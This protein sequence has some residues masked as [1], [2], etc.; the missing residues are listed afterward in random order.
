[1]FLSNCWSVANK[2]DLFNNYV[3]SHNF[4]CYCLT[5]TKLDAKVD[6]KVFG[7]R[8]YSIF[9]LD[10]SRNAGGVAIFLSNLINCRRVTIN[11]DGVFSFDIVAVDI[12]QCTG[13]NFRVICLYRPPSCSFNDSLKLF[14]T[15]SQLLRNVDDFLVCGDFNFPEMSWNPPIPHSAVSTVLVDLILQF[16]MTQ[17]VLSATHRDG[18]IL[19]LV[20]GSDEFLVSNLSVEAPI[21]ADHFCVTFD[22][23]IRISQRSHWISFTQYSKCQDLEVFLLNIDWD[24]I[25]AGTQSY[26][27]VW[28]EFCNLMEYGIKNFIPVKKVSSNQTHFFDLKVDTQNAMREKKRIYDIWRKNQVS[29]WKYLL[30]F[31]VNKCRELVARDR[32]AYENDIRVSGDQ[33]RFFSHVKNVLQ[34]VIVIPQLFDDEGTYNDDLSKANCLNR[35]FCNVFT[36]SNGLTPRFDDRTDV[37][38]EDVVF[39]PEMVLKA[40]GKLSTS[41]SA[42]VDN[43]PSVVLKKCMVPLADPLSRLYNCCM[44][45]EALPT[46]WSYA[47]VTAIYKGVGSPMLP[48]HYRPVS[49]TVVPCKVM[50][51]CLKDIILDHLLEHSLLN[52]R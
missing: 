26:T 35:F 33:K 21:F 44:Q 2:V 15:I 46:D 37:H 11:I 20:M 14:D 1:M 43:I 40:L 48:N 6:D 16:S 4:A 51:S 29:F 23:N 36:V 28:R 32:A 7:L 31:W 39:T 10:R 3:K 8:D 5:E 42:G 9:R 13:S 18:N 47:N 12:V 49:I 41:Y 45:Y 52:W 19:D 38:I 34:R 30:A 17:F 25:F 22:V 50:E 24:I 27:D